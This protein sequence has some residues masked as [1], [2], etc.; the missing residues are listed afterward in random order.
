[1][2]RTLTDLA[3][4][5]A[6]HVGEGLTPTAMPNVGL[7]KVSR[8]IDLL[9]E[10]YR[11]VVSLILQ[12]E[13]QLSIGD[14]LLT[15]R[16]GHTFT[17]ALDLPVMAKIT[18][19]TTDRPYLAISLAVEARIVSDLVAKMPDAGS[20]ANRKAFAIDPADHDLLDA[21]RRMLGLIDRPEDV[22]I[23]APLLE[24]EIVYRLLQGPQGTILKQ[25][26]S[27]DP[28]V[29]PIRKALAMIAETYTRSFRVEDIARSAGMSC[30]AFHRRFK[31]ATGMAP[32]QYQKTLRLYEAR[33]LLLTEA[34]S[35][36][37]AAFSVGYQSVSQFSRE[38]RRLF[39]TPPMREARTR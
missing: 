9:P 35:A 25:I 14:E 13:K 30:S 4:A 39:G 22:P 18:K 34:T 16:A 15:Y 5:V 33:R 12:G 29:A 36:S 7:Y 10:T 6:R 2:D 37:T 32:L 28:R 38:Y 26:A 21:W 24:Q 31:A 27:A 3:C 11:P 23:M 20:E 1:M 17:A 8:C 19:A